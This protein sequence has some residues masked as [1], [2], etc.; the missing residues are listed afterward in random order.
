MKTQRFISTIRVA[1]LALSCAAFLASCTSENEEANEPLYTLG[2]PK[3]SS[4]QGSRCFE[5]T[6]FTVEGE[7]IALNYEEIIWTFKNNGTAIAG[8]PN[9]VLSGSWSISFVDGDQQL[10]LD[11][12]DAPPL[13]DAVA[14]TWMVVN[15]GLNNPQ[16]VN[17]EG[18]ILQFTS[19]TCPVVSPELEALNAF[20]EDSIF[21]VANFIYQ[22]N[23]IT[24]RFNNITL[25]FNENDKVIAERFGQQRIG[26]WLTS[27]TEDG[28][29]L[30]LQFN[31]PPQLLTGF[32]GVWN[33]VS[34][35][36]TGLIGEYYDG[37]PATGDYYRYELSD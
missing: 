14:G 13:I 35:N 31:A 25:D 1:F 12:P 6:E 26:Q 5:L 19:T 32:N 21:T 29:T 15:L 9:Q 17:D 22:D 16:F 2:D 28:I 34:F 33:I 36:S 24:D 3:N 7:G 30:I 11:F 4:P 10:F 27:E 37:P 8:S 18:D 20:L 23:D